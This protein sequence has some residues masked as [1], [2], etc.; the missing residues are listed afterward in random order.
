MT[1]QPMTYH[2]V[3]SHVGRRKANLDLKQA[4][5]DLADPA[6]DVVDEIN[7][8]KHEALAADVAAEQLKLEETLLAA[9]ASIEHY[10]RE[11]EVLTA[12]HAETD[13]TEARMIPADL[14]AEHR[15]HSGTI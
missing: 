9:A 1:Y 12:R 5:A 10:R 6:G 13:A 7:T 14:D 15:T 3:T 8:P 11:V 2:A 4:L